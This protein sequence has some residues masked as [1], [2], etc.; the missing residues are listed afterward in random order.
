[1]RHKIATLQSGCWDGAH[2]LPAILEGG[3]A[4]EAA[5]VSAGS[6]AAA[7]EGEGE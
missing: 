1:M 2:R 7:V 3:A 6:A 5:V 4:A